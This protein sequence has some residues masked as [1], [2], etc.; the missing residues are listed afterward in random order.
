[1]RPPLLFELTM[2][3]IDR[4]IKRARNIAYRYLTIRPRSC[5]E[6]E[7][8][9]GDRG[10]SPAVVSAVVSHLLRLGSLNDE[11]FARQ[12][13]AGRLR[14]KGLG[15][16]RIEQELRVRGIDRDTI[17]AVVT[18][19]LKESAEI[20][21]ARK[22]AERKLSTLGRFEPEVRKR[23]LAGFLERKGFGAEIIRSI[24]RTVK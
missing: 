15:R 21:I 4:D 5:R 9:L 10:F 19:L 11:E 8:K 6:V 24:I 14:T 16:R 20:D 12:W 17:D 2:E 13:G 1:M 18:D 22:E 7:R 3:E 23:R